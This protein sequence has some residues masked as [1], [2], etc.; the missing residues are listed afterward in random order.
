MSP[1]STWFNFL[2]KLGLDLGLI[3]KSRHFSIIYMFIFQD[4]SVYNSHG[5]YIVY[6]WDVVMTL[7]KSVDDI[8]WNWKSNLNACMQV[9]REQ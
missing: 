6:S 9:G 2:S 4:S 7:K 8:N 5:I 1:N 3:E